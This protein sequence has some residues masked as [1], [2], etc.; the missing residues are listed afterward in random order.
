VTSRSPL[1]GEVLL[2]SARFSM[3]PV[4]LCAL[5]R[6]GPSSSSLVLSL[7]TGPRRALGL[8]IATAPRGLDHFSWT[9][10][11]THAQ[12]TSAHTWTHKQP[13]DT[14]DDGWI[15]WI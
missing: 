2:K 7:A 11:K 13:L 12:S 4:C 15:H 1:D 6:S 8:S 10:N 5:A 9:T 14:S 3:I